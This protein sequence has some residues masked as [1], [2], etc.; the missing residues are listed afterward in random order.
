M[1]YVG[2]C[3]NSS[4]VALPCPCC[5]QCV[6]KLALCMPAK[7]LVCACCVCPYSCYVTCT[8][9]CYLVVEF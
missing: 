7:N 6:A 9:G 1:S 4:Y 2:Y 3:L 8:A 5:T